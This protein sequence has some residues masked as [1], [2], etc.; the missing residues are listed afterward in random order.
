M[1]KIQSTPGMQN[2]HPYIKSTQRQR[3]REIEEPNTS[4]VD[5]HAA[6]RRLKQNET[7]YCSVPAGPPGVAAPAAGPLP[8]P[9]PW[10]PCPGRQPR[11]R[12]PAVP[13]RRLGRCCYCSSASAFG[14]A[15]RAAGSGTALALM[16]VPRWCGRVHR[17]E[18]NKHKIQQRRFGLA[19]CFVDREAVEKIALRPASS[20][21][22]GRG[23]RFSK[24][25]AQ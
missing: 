12:G 25:G 2:P 8:L 9:L 5:G 21:G 6:K 13:P 17:P 1:G 23:K 16:G 24:P 3:K 4:R 20:G 22:W 10:A 18:K 15:T 14:C 7:V 11:G 19:E